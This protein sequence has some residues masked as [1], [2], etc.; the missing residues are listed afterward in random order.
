METLESWLRARAEA[1]PI[2][3]KARR[4]LD[5]MVSVPKFAAYASAAQ[6]GKRAGVDASTVVRMAHT[7]GFDG[8]PDLQSEIRSRYLS[9]LSASQLLETHDDTASDPIVRALRSDADIAAQT[10]NSMDVAAI[11]KIAAALLESRRIVVLAS[12]SFA[13]PATQLVHVATRLGLDIHLADRGGRTLVTSLAALDAGDAVLIINLWRLP[14]EV[15]AAATWAKTNG[16]RVATITDSL[17]GPLAKASDHVVTIPTEGT[18]HFPSL[19]PAMSLV[20]ALLAEFTHVLGEGGR[21]AIE[22]NDATY[23]EMERLRKEVSS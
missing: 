19:V 12:G 3:P 20:H 8:W 16:V 9:S 14:A 23:R 11:R 7:L 13:G 10:A 15:L 2:G 5:L 17:H 22:R 18:S 1:Q 4:L 6:I 21:K